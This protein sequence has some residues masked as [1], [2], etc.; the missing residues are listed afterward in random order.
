M[1][2]IKEYLHIAC[3]VA[4]LGFIAWLSHH[5]RAAEADKIYAARAAADLKA[6]T[7]INKV[8]ADATATIQDLQVRLAATLAAPPPSP[9]VVRL[10]QRSRPIQVA[11]WAEAQGPGSSGNDTGGPGPGVAGPSQ[12]GPD[13]GP[14]TELIL[15]R[16]GAKLKFL[17]GYV[18]ACQDAGV[19]ETN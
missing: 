8:T 6:L 10:R 1:L 16:V 17:Q 4:A 12:E 13:I 15:N 3:L 9:V 11:P 2:P 19:C 5:E 14:G 7:R 18:K